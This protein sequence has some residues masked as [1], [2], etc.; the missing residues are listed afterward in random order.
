MLEYD[1]IKYITQ[2]NQN[3]MNWN[4][5]VYFILK[6][7]VLNESNV[8]RKFK[9]YKFIDNGNTEYIEFFEIYNCEAED[10]KDFTK[11]TLSFSGSVIISG[12]KDSMK[13]KIFTR[14]HKIHNMYAVGYE[15]DEYE[16]I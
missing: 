2:K 5:D 9:N 15:E 11:G 8:F 6:T 14:D 16:F 1:L 12:V 3:Y 4:D 10:Y 7:V 13:L